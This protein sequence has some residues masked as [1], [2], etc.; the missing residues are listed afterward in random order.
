[1]PITAARR[2]PLLT[3]AA[4]ALEP[5]T[6]APAVAAPAVDAWTDVSTAL[7]DSLKAKGITTGYPGGC[8]GVVVNRL[9]GE[10]T[11]KVIGCG[12]WRSGD[13]GATWARIDANTIGGRDETG[14]AT[15]ADPADPRRL[16]SFSLDGPAGWTVD[17][18][19]WKAFAGLGRNWDYGSVDWSAAA[20]QTIIA[21]RHE[22]TPAGE[23]YVSTDGGQH[24]RKLAVLLG[25]DRGASAMV[26]ALG[27]AT[28]IYS[29]GQ[30]IER[31]TDAGAT[32]Q[33]VA[34]ANPLTRVPVVFGG[35]CYLGTADGLLV[36]RDAGATWQ[37]QGAPLKIRLGPFFGADEKQILAAGDDGVFRSRDGGGSWTRVCGLQTDNKNYPF[38]TNWFGCYAWDPI[39]GLVY[40]SA[41]GHPVYAL[42]IP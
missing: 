39:H 31:S 20:P 27:G 40:A 8:S 28:V 41:M 34:A 32:W 19:T 5:L 15:S 10:V 14:W 4:L 37:T 33:P 24:W 11:I 1:M 2:L 22:T 38:S 26:G 18:A 30:G 9:T 36:S 3:L 16:V 25:G 17:G 35:V 42:K 7:V 23:V 29:H 21:A 6:A 12:L 13:Q